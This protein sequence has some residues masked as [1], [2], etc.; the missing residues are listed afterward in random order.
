MCVCVCVRGIDRGFLVPF[1]FC[2]HLAEEDCF[3]SVL[4][5]E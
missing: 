1:K 5:V 4:A 3:N 2:N